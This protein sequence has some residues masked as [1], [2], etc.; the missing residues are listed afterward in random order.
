MRNFGLGL[1]S[2]VILSGALSACTSVVIQRGYVPD[3]VAV[4]SV[5][6][7]TDT[8]ITVAQ[9]LGNPS[10]QATFGGDV[11]YYISARE[12]QE[13]FFPPVITDRHILAIEFNGQGQV[14][15]IRH[16]GLQDGRIVDYVSR[17]TPTRGK[18]LTII[19]QM[20]NAIPGV[21]GATGAQPGQQ[22]P[23]GGTGMPGGGPY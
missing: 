14:A 11:W 5:A 12:E 13:A 18:E 15:N 6:I 16:Y 10:T 4:G 22:G 3:Q 19:Q 20:F 1:L 2:A 8:K 21:T 23:G 9:K 7:G 17:E